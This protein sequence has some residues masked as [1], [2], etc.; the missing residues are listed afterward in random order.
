MASSQYIL[1]V[2]FVFAQYFY[3]EEDETKEF[4]KL[5]SAMR[6]M[7]RPLSRHLSTTGKKKQ[8]DVYGEFFF[9]FFF[10]LMLY[11]RRKCVYLKRGKRQTIARFGSSLLVSLSRPHIQTKWRR[12]NR[13]SNLRNV[14]SIETFAFV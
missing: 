14:V 3:I 12:I 10:F 13:L 6:A 7:R 11:L 5:E 2:Y 8:D 9:F 4:N 1:F